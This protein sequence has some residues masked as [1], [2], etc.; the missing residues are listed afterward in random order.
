MPPVLRD[1]VIL[2][3]PKGGNMDLSQ[4]TNYRGIALASCFS[5][6]L[7]CCILE[8]LGSCLL[9][10][11]LQFGFK[12]GLS[13]TLC[14]GVMKATISQYLA[15]GSCVYGC[16]VDAS[17]AFDTVDNTLLLEKLLK[18]DLPMC[19]SFSAH[20]VSNATIEGEMEWCPI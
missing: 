3:I 6:L 4:S 8:D 12:L 9:S 10:S 5:K 18:R 2:P 17:K 16:L 14:T 11:H 19:C 1:A 15:G 20:L 13:T 7:E